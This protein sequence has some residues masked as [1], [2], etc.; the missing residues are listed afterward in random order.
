MAMSAVEA[1][2]KE[3]DQAER[4][5][6]L[7]IEVRD[8]LRKVYSELTAA[9]KIDPDVIRHQHDY[10]GMGIIEAAE[11]WL[12]EVADPEGRTTAEIRDAILARG[13]TTKSTGRFIQV[14]HASLRNASH[15]FKRVGRGSNKRWALKNSAN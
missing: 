15:I 3:L 4:D 7:Q 14:V 6:A 10:S 1:V 13:V 8:R 11:K 9:S 5:A 2:K 12:T